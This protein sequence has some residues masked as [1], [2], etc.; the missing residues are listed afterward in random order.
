MSIEL[1][2]IQNQKSNSL[3]D[4]KG[5]FLLSGGMDS[6]TLF[7]Q[8]LKGGYTLYPVTFDYGQKHKAAENE[9]AFRIH[10]HYHNI[11]PSQ[12]M[13]M[14]EIQLDLSN[15]TISTLVTK[16]LDI[17]KN[18][19]GQAKTV[20]PHRN[21]LMTTLAASYG[22]GL[23]I[24]NIFITPVHEDF[25]IYRDCRREFIDALEKA[26]RLSAG[27]S[28]LCIFTPYIH[29]SKNEIIA[30]GI[31]NAVP[32]ELSWSCYLGGKIDSLGRIPC[33]MEMEEDI[34]KLHKHP[35][36]CS[37]CVKEGQRVLMAD[38]SQK[39]IEK[40]VAGDKI[41]SFNEHTY[42][43]EM[44]EVR[45]VI[46][47]GSKDVL[48]F[49]TLDGKN[50]VYLTE[51]HKVPVRS[52][53]QGLKWREFRTLKRKDA[54]Y[55]TYIWNKNYIPEDAENFALGYLRGFVDGDGSYGK[56]GIS[57][58]QKEESVLIEFISLYN[59][60]VASTKALVRRGDRGVKGGTLMYY[61]GVGY[62]PTFEK[63]TYFRRQT[64]YLMGYL[65][66]III[67]DGGVA[68]NT[69][70]QAL[71][72]QIS[73]KTSTTDIIKNIKDAFNFLGIKFNE[74]SALTKGAKS[75]IKEGVIMTSIQIRRCWRTPFLYGGLKRLNIINKMMEHYDI[76][77]FEP[78][79]VVK[80]AKDMIKGAHVYDLTTTSGT[81]ICEGFP[82]HNCQERLTSFNH[83]NIKDP[84]IVS[85][86]NKR[87]TYDSKI[88]KH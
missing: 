20:V 55:F 84:L 41:F 27:N 7:A 57:I 11:Y 86:F 28:G 77:N 87:S 6:S 32:Y 85:I 80:D 63:K 22:A 50:K 25:E 51:D 18:M 54:S 68:Y 36:G 72:C 43:L 71:N 4:K 45:N 9:A 52:R 67:S 12:V 26:L 56:R 31:K 34:E 73:Q 49:K 19:E 29:R 62:T 13:P 70:T 78:Q 60:Y 37:A 66:G 76:H 53:G 48:A 16:G 47:N 75:Y 42:A 39:P 15:I 64:D 38:Y 74:T 21:A 17:P 69:S 61:A 81:F 46:D 79:Q 8:L 24:Y 35:V 88:S 2:D 59:K 30:W 44:S 14:K 65:N 1:L 33:C 58:Y 3:A 5:I 82:V 40:V 10:Q 23:E 83:N